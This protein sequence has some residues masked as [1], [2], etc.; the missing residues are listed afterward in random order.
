METRTEIVSSGQVT[1]RWCYA[2]FLVFLMMPS[3]M[4]GQQSDSLSVQTRR[5]FLYAGVSSSYA[6][7]TN[8]DGRDLRNFSLTAN[9][10]YT[11][12]G[13]VGERSHAHQV[14]A[15]V[16]YL[17]YVDS[18]WVKSLDKLQVN[19]MWASKGLRM[20][21]SYSVLLSTQFL[22]NSTWR[23][24]V[25]QD[26][27]LEQRLGGLLRPF[28]LEMGY[29][30]VFSFWEKSTINFAFA[31][32]KLSGYPKDMVAPPFRDAT[33]IHAP[34]TNYYA[35]YGIG[36]IAAINKPIGK[37]LVWLNNS[38]AFCNG[39]DSDHANFDVSNMLII[40]LWKYVQLRFDTRLAYNPVINY[41]LR[42]RQE[43]LVGFFY[44]RKK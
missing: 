24:D 30:A 33:L 35:S 25:E 23:Y 19:L 16:G 20:K 26:R 17:K 31:T 4:R 34:S 29:G 37:H 9:V 7:S 13:I 32:L 14:L 38:R 2:T 39:F 11:H 40:K 22:P 36:L 27:M 18:I 10:Q 41:D 42:F 3:G 5:S 12:G 44:E 6:T 28:S 21:H 15:D 43:V 8:W 1:I